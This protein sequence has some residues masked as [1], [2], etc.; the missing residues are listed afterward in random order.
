MIKTDK[1][2]FT[3]VELLVVISII[4]FLTTTAIVMLQDAR[5]KSRDGKRVAEL[6]RMQTALE[7]YYDKFQT[8]PSEKACD[9]SI[10]SNDTS[11][12]AAGTDWD[13]A[14]SIVMGLKN[15]GIMATLPKDPLNNTTFYY[16]YEPDCNQG[17][18]PTS[19]CRYNITARL[20]KGGT[21]T[22][23]GEK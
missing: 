9:S 11:C 22:L 10:G 23:T 16:Q 17:S 12:P 1:T 13:P 8:Y 20:E 5:K 21:F 18:C 3:L 15:S 19:C 7:M 6:K 2:G 14:A 4:S